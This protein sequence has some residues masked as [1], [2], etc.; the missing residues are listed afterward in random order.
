[1][2][3]LSFRVWQIRA[4]SSKTIYQLYPTTYYPLTT[5][6]GATEK[7]SPGSCSRL[8][9]PKNPKDLASV[10]DLIPNQSIGIALLW[11]VLEG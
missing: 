11:W 10:E 4:P 7:W 9:T 3:V 6:A 5:F 2:K 8:S 1:M